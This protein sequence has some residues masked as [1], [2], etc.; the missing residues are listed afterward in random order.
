MTNNR[1]KISQELLQR[2]REGNLYYGNLENIV[3][4]LENKEVTMGDLGTNKDEL[5]G[6][7]EKL[8][9]RFLGKPVGNLDCLEKSRLYTFHRS[10][11][12][13]PKNL[14]FG[15]DQPS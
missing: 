4:A 11:S 12:R 9:R 14:Q 6:L 8:H 2:A 13:I 5:R 7:Y 1:M 3:D 15:V 10:L